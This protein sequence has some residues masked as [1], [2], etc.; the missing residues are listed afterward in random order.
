MPRRRPPQLPRRPL[1]AA[2]IKQR[3]ETLPARPWCAADQ[4]HVADVL[5][6][7]WHLYRLALAENAAL[8]Q[9]LG[10]RS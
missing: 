8:R 2:L 5:A 1:M 7:L 10:G 3:I 6:D 4:H 9:R